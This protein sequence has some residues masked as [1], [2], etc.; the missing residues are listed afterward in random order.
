MVTDLLSEPPPEVQSLIDEQMADMRI[1]AA[2]RMRLDDLLA[3]AGITVENVG[4]VIERMQRREAKI[5]R[6]W[7]AYMEASEEE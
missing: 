2:R 7:G 1:V 3:R 5:K 6:L 4:M